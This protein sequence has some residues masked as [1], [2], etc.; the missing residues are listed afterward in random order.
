MCLVWVENPYGA[1]APICLNRTEPIWI[2]PLGSKGAAGSVKRVFGR[3][4]SYGHGTQTSHVYLQPE[5]GG[6]FVSCAVGAVTPYA[7]EFTIPA[8]LANGHYRLYVHSGHGGRYGWGGPLDLAVAEPWSRGSYTTN[9]APSGGDDAPALQ[10]A[11]DNVSSQANGGTVSLAAGTFALRSGL[12]LR[13]QV[14]LAGAG[15]TDTTL[16]VTGSTGVAMLGDRMAVRDLTLRQQAGSPQMAILGSAYEGEI[17]LAY[18]GADGTSVVVEIGAKTVSLPVVT[19]VWTHVTVTY[20]H[21]GG[22]NGRSFFTVY[23]NGVFAGSNPYALPVERHLGTMSLGARPRGD[24]MLDGAVDAVLFATQCLAAAAVTNIYEQYRSG[25]V[26]AEGLLRYNFNDAGKQAGDVCVSTVNAGA[27]GGS[28]SGHGEVH[29]TAGIA[30]GGDLAV[31]GHNVSNRMVTGPAVGFVRGDFSLAFAVR[32]NGPQE[33]NDV[34][35]GFNG[36][37]NQ[38]VKLT[39]VRY[40][41]EDEVVTGICSL[42]FLRGEMEAC[43]S[44]YRTQLGRDGWVHGCTGHGGSNGDGAYGEGQQCIIEDSHAETPNWPDVGGNRQYKE[45]LSTNEQVWRVWCKRLWWGSATENMYIAGNTATNV[46]ADE[47]KGEMILFHGGVREWFAEVLSNDGLTLTVR[48][49]G[50]YRGQAGFQVDEAV[51]GPVPDALGYDDTIDGKAYVVVVRGPGVGQMRQVVAHTSNTLTVADAWRVAPTGATVVLSRYFRNNIVYGNDLSAFPAGY[52]LRYSASLPVWFWGNCAFNVAESNTSRRTWSAGGIV[53]FQSAPSFWNELRGNRAVDCDS[54]GINCG[55]GFRTPAFNYIGPF[56]LGNAIRDCTVEIATSAYWWKAETALLD[57]SIAN[58]GNFNAAT[59]IPL[60]EGNV[61]ENS[62]FSRYSRGLWAGKWTANLIRGNR[63]TALQDEP[64]SLY[65][66]LTNGY[67]TARA[68]HVEPYGYPLLSSNTYAGADTGYH[69]ATNHF[70]AGLPVPLCRAA[71]VAGHAGEGPVHVMV[72]MANAGISNMAW[73]VSATSHTWIA[74]EVRAGSSPLAPET[75][76]GQ[77]LVTVDRHS[78]SQGQSLGY[79]TLRT[80]ET[81]T[82]VGVWAELD[83]PLAIPPGTIFLFY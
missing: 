45:L 32:L 83:K 11:I 4:L 44:A 68:V 75:V 43:V 31:E 5:G 26:A 20:D 1:S 39:R 80:A 79:V 23:R 17:P 7:V 24:R 53:G 62:A 77:L 60:S 30:G 71:R 73:T 13:H 12:T 55:G 34:I 48:A 61:V 14:E 38:D 46:A 27:V 81:S 64:W 9:V 10:A 58:A 70:L 50:T 37:Y 36:D 25:A 19:G 74:A 28:A 18:M 54:N 33:P 42:N 22:S 57:L 29:Y 76:G 35:V 72:P 78:L 67:L 40:E 3:N 16:M 59:D 52:K 82:T 66:T 2:G 69:P 8:G 56:V 47:N 51:T 21:L 15:M 49:D 41:P 6:D 63:F 65:G